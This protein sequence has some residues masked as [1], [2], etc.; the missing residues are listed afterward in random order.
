MPTE[1]RERVESVL[2]TYVASEWGLDPA[3]IE[4]LAVADGIASVRLSGACSS[5]PGGI[6]V[7]IVGME[8][9][10]REPV[11]EVEFVEFVP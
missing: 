2:R 3:G 9:A 5:C 1:L 10:L 6:H 8:Q 11:P 4:V 7:F